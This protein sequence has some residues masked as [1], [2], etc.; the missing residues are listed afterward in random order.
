MTSQVERR[1]R[2]REVTGS[3]YISLIRYLTAYVVTVRFPPL[4]FTKFHNSGT[5]TRENFSGFPLEL[6]RQV[7][8][9]PA[10]SFNLEVQYKVEQF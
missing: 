4:E 7:K 1:H 8:F 5:V 2:A 10:L 6:H 3:L 9:Y